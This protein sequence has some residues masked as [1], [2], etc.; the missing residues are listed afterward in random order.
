MRSQYMIGNIAN[1]TD[2]A[3]RSVISLCHEHDIAVHNN[4]IYPAYSPNYIQGDNERNA[5]NAWLSLTGVRKLARILFPA[6]SFPGQREAFLEDMEMQ[7][8]TLL[9]YMEV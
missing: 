3:A 2:R 7:K 8:I 5:R 4:I 6:G 1:E 9:E